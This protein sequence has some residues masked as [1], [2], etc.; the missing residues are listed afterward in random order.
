M[1]EQFFKNAGNDSKSMNAI[2]FVYYTAPDFLDTDPVKL[3]IYGSIRRNFTKAKEYFT[4][5]A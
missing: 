4:L 1:A 3:S 2:G 5:S